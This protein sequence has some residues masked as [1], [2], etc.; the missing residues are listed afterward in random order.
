[1]KLVSYSLLLSFGLWSCMGKPSASLAQ[2]T[3]E[4]Q[5]QPRQEDFFSDTLQF[6]EER[7]NE[8]NLLGVF[9][10]QKLDT[11][12][13]VWDELRKQPKKD[14]MYDCQWTMKKVV[15]G[16][17]ETIHYQQAF[18][19]KH[20]PV[21]VLPFVNHGIPAD[22]RR[23]N[24]LFYA[25]GGTIGYLNDGTVVGCPRCDPS[26]ENAKAMLHK[27]P[28]GTYRELED[29]RLL[30]NGGIYEYPFLNEEQE[31]NDWIIFNNRNEWLNYIQPT[32]EFVGKTYKA[33]VGF[34]CMETP[35]PD[36]CAGRQIDLILKFNS[37]FA[38]VVTKEFSPC[39]TT[40]LDTMNVH[41]FTK[42]DT[43]L[44]EPGLRYL[45]KTL[46]MND[47]L[48]IENNQLKGLRNDGMYDEIIFEEVKSKKKN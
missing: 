42:K 30:V 33:R 48:R 25:N 6:L 14:A 32:P 12:A 37:D 35:D 40:F 21:S 38:E 41:W 8:D 1:M 27:P 13:I 36:P 39:E 24:Y 18:M 17:D 28:M 2:E 15:S 19:V 22:Q 10:S 16:G 9:I 5:P 20:K 46:L 11:F 34:I 44:F 7:E 29:G 3:A 45:E 31:F 26:P 43:I 4:Q 47:K 23:L